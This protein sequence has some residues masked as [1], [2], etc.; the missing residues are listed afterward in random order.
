MN[1][2]RRGGRGF[3]SYPVRTLG[4]MGKAEVFLGRGL[5]CG[6]PG[7]EGC[8]EDYRAGWSGPAGCGAAADG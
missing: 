6:H 3:V 2:V 4:A 5:R 7:E 8:L 1:R